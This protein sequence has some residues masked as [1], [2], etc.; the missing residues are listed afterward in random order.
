[1]VL[2]ALIVGVAAGYHA[3][4]GNRND[5]AILMDDWSASE[6]ALVARSLSTGYPVDCPRSGLD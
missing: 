4:A 2:A 3:R 5:D 6:H 1:M